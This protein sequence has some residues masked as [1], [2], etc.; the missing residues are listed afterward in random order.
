MDT[1]RV[2]Y[3]PKQVNIQVHNPAPRVDRTNKYFNPVV[4]NRWAGYF[5]LMEPEKRV[6]LDLEPTPAMIFQHVP[7]FAYYPEHSNIDVRL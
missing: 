7:S 5:P 3:T 1:L 6:I 2:Y 4:A